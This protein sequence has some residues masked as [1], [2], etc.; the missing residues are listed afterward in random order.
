MEENNR[1]GP[2]VF[3]AV[4][5][6]AT[7]VVAIIGAT[8]AYFS[9][10][11]TP[12]DSTISGNTMNMPDNTLSL[13]VNKVTFTNT[14]VTDN[15]LVPA[16]FGQN[17]QEELNVANPAALGESNIEAMLSSKCVEVNSA[18]GK[19]YTGCHLYQIT[20][21]TSETVPYANLWL[22]L[23]S[24]TAT[25]KDQWGYAVFKTTAS[26]SDI[27]GGTSG[28]VTY[29]TVAGSNHGA[30]GTGVSRFDIHNNAGLTAGT[31][32]IYY[33]LIYV[34]DDNAVQNAS[35]AAAGKTNVIGSYSGQV[36][37]DAMGGKVRASFAS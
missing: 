1:K 32:V 8:F 13:N 20:A 17:A 30:I 18:Q 11:T 4:V 26:L 2:G 29:P 22:T 16:Y 3:Y 10:S 33:L 14:G 36:E 31:P 9:A 15:N 34:N 6:V 19:S 12:D 21:S 7:L 28:T 5:G 27:Q 25:D 37:L 24:V 35:T 23:D